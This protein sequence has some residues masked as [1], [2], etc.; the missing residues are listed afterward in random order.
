MKN[1]LFLVG[2]L[3]QHSLN[4]RLSLIAASLLPEGYEATHFD[5]GT[6]PLYSSDIDAEN[7][8]A[9]VVA[10]RDALRAADGVFFTAPEYNYSLPGVVKNAI[11]WASRPMMPRNAIVGR[12]MNAVV[13][14]MSPTNGIRGL[15]ELK[16]CWSLVGG[17][18]VGPIDFVL[19]SAQTR[20][21]ETEGNDDLE[22]AAKSAVHAQISYLVNAIENNA[23][24]TV[25]GNWD[26]FIGSMG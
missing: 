4:K 17:F 7:S 8:P 15:S 21:V 24:A 22:P 23:G 25:L 9:S 16:R 20:F 3:R 19:Q 2:S 26:S 11:D 5:I 1:V 12:P 13:A 14:T 6:L 18:A 10:F